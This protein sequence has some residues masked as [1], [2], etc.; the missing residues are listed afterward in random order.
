QKIIAGTPWRR[1]YT[2]NY[3][4]VIEFGAAQTS[5]RLTPVTLGD[6][7]TK[8][9]KQQGLAIHL[10]GFVDRLARNNLWSELKLTDA[11]YLVAPVTDSPW[12]V[13]FRQD[14]ALARSIFFVGWSASDLDIR[15]LLGESGNLV[16][17]CFF[18]LGDKP[19]A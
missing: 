3:D 5:K 4:N 10:N 1:V 14:V 15:R 13:L 18:V 2:T 8:I 12:A 19:D 6:D 17:R 9:S 11:S 16:D 7:I